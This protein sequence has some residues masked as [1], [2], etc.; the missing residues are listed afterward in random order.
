MPLQQRAAAACSGCPPGGSSE[1]SLVDVGS[2]HPALPFRVQF[3]GEPWSQGEGGIHV[4]GIVWGFCRWL[5]FS[6]GRLSVPLD[7]PLA[8]MMRLHAEAAGTSGLHNNRSRASQGIQEE[9]WRE[10]QVTRGVTGFTPRDTV[11]IEFQPAIPALLFK[12]NDVY[13]EQRDAGAFASQRVRSTELVSTGSGG[14][15]GSTFRGMQGPAPLPTPRYVETHQGA[16]QALYHA[17]RDRNM[18]WLSNFFSYYPHWLEAQD[19]AATPGS[20]TFAYLEHRMLVE[21]AGCNPDGVGTGSERITPL[22][23][24]AE[25]GQDAIV[26]MLAASY[27]LNVNRRDADGNSAL[28]RVALRAAGHSSAAG[29]RLGISLPSP[30]QGFLSTVKMLL[31]LGADCT[32]RNDAGLTPVDIISSLGDTPQDGVD[33]VAKL[34]QYAA[35]TAQMQPCGCRP[36][37]KPSSASHMEACRGGK[38]GSTAASVP[39]RWGPLLANCTVVV[40]GPGSIAFSLQSL[41]IDGERRDNPSLETEREAE[42]A[43]FAGS[44]DRTSVQSPQPLSS[45]AASRA[46]ETLTEEWQGQMKLQDLKTASQSLR[47]NTRDGGDKR[48]SS[49]SRVGRTSTSLVAS[50]CT[51]AVVQQLRCVNAASGGAA[52][53]EITERSDNTPTTDSACRQSTDSAACQTPPSLLRPVDKRLPLTSADVRTLLQQ[54]LLWGLDLFEASSASSSRSTEVQPRILRAPLPAAS[55]ALLSSIAMAEDFVSLQH[56]FLAV[57]RRLLTLEVQHQH[58]E[59]QHSRPPMHM[60]NG[61]QTTAASSQ[62]HR[63]SAG[64][65]SQSDASRSKH[66]SRGEV[67]F[68]LGP[69]LQGIS[70]QYLAALAENAEDLGDLASLLLPLDTL[71][72]RIEGCT[73]P[74]WIDGMQRHMWRQ[75]VARDLGIQVAL[76]GPGGLVWTPDINLLARASGVELQG[77]PTPRLLL[78][79][80]ASSPEKGLG[81]LVVRSVPASDDVIVHEVMQL[82]PLKFDVWLRQLLDLFESTDENRGTSPQAEKHLR[83]AALVSKADGNRD[84]L[85]AFYRRYSHQMAKRDFSEELEQAAALKEEVLAQLREVSSRVATSSSGE[86]LLQQVIGLRLRLL[87]H[88]NTC[89]MRAVP[90]IAPIFNIP[91]LPLDCYGLLTAHLG[92]CFFQGNVSSQLEEPKVLRKEAWRRSYGKCKMVLQVGPSDLP[93]EMSAYLF[94]RPLLTNAAVG[95]LWRSLV[96]KLGFSNHDQPSVRLD[97]GQ[98]ATAKTLAHTLWYQATTQLLSSAASP[99]RLRGRV[100]DRPFMVVFRGEGA[101]DF[102]GP[103]QEFLS[104]VANEVMG[105]LAE[106]SDESLPTFL[107]CLPCLNS[108][109]AIG[110]R[111]D[112]V[113]L[114]PDASMSVPDPLISALDLLSQN[115]AEGQVVTDGPP[116]VS[117][118]S[119]S[120]TEPQHDACSA[121]EMN[122][123]ADIHIPQA[124][125]ALSVEAMHARQNSTNGDSHTMSQRQLSRLLRVDTLWTPDSITSALPSPAARMRARVLASEASAP[126]RQARQDESLQPQSHHREAAT[127]LLSPSSSASAA[128]APPQPEDDLPNEEMMYIMMYEALGRLMAM[129]FC[130]GS[131]FNV[132]FNPLLWKKLVAAPISIDDVLDSDC[133]SVEMIRSLRRMAA[134]PPQFWDSAMEASLSDMTFC[135]EDTLGRSFELV[136]GG[137]DIPVNALNLNTFIRLSE[138][139]R[140][141]EGTEGVEALLRGFGAV[142]PLGRIRL[143]F[144]WRRLEY[145][146]CGDR[147][148]DVSVLKEHTVCSSERLKGQLFQIL[149]SFNNE[150]MQRFLRFVCGRSRLPVASSEWRMT[151][152]YETPDQRIPS[153]NDNR[154][155]TAATCSFRLLVPRYSSVAIMR[156]RLLYAINNCTAIDLDAFVVHEQ[157]QLMYDD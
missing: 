52:N 3:R 103:F 19:A 64:V 75:R 92:S 28:H 102:G 15:V 144:D 24:A 60:H 32:I 123:W 125:R 153:V 34:L 10:T 27:G 106:S 148:V 55:T 84:D 152:D 146:V 44:I 81:L 67:R 133:V 56:A 37:S 141:L 17:I 99:C 54:L 1:S 110:P 25:L 113:V 40:G 2:V 76:G 95:G 105:S 50:N 101:T 6:N 57:I 71:A 29:G 136:E 7:L 78:G 20:C 104:G 90:V 42:A 72:A 41:Y 138:K 58:K 111:Q 63:P 98:A 119:Q 85:L 5:W 26:A 145:R 35:V 23:L 80:E 150:Q 21:D 128:I 109:H 49:S 140:L 16:V 61:Q 120:C 73:Q 87:D 93:I 45:P 156:K 139:F 70:L 157:M 134:V 97:R 137:A 147:E 9:S 11:E 151:V 135:A 131:A 121:E 46:S 122:Q 100:G 77:F 132:T 82:W 74:G 118:H 22:M 143:L 47:A 154:L 79:E 112:S 94:V 124:S 91:K 108:A 51:P 48:A 88:L 36:H 126:S 115:S 13:Q 38:G 62:T 155:P 117:S 4:V 96:E 83:I 65:A 68:S 66:S 39:W 30:K 14:A 8:E 130:I 107:A 89:A 149:E 12:K 116:Q 31:S 86:G 114:R 69:P 33:A 18:R 59:E 53:A 129:C 127:P 142:L 43:V